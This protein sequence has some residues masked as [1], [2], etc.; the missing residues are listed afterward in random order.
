ML[1][2]LPNAYQ[3]SF[4]GA[5]LRCEEDTANIGARFIAKEVVTQNESM[6]RKNSTLAH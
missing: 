3:D 2:L 5:L 4:S 1:D 6:K